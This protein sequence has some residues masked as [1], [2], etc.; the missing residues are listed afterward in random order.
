LAEIHRFYPSN[1]LDLGQPGT[2]R[3]KKGKDPPQSTH[4]RMAAGM[5][6]TYYPIPGSLTPTGKTLNNR[7]DPFF[8]I[9]KILNGLRVQQAVEL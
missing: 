7:F 4:I 5:V 2:K 8:M 1:L 9:P 3:L 6:K